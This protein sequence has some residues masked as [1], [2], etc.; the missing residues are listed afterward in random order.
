[1][2]PSNS[3]NPLNRVPPQPAELPPSYQQTQE[4]D[5]A[6]S[7]KSREILESIAGFT[8]ARKVQI[9]VLAAKT[10]NE[11]PGQGPHRIYFSATGAS[12][13]GVREVREAPHPRLNQWIKDKLSFLDKVQLGRLAFATGHW[14]EFKQS[15]D[16]NPNSVNN[17]ISKFFQ[18]YFAREGTDQ[19]TLKLWQILE[20]RLFYPGV[21]DKLETALT[22]LT[23]YPV[24]AIQPDGQSSCNHAF[25][26][27]VVT[28]I[29]I[30][31]LSTGD[32]GRLGHYLKITNETTTRIKD[33][34]RDSALG[35]YAA[36]DNFVES[37]GPEENLYQKLLLALDRRQRRDIRE[38][39]EAELKRLGIS[40]GGY[41][42]H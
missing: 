15:V 7:E 20:H 24:E 29:V 31:N 23:E 12:Q 4:D 28:R 39:L 22:S 3:S 35:L 42:S 30:D 5:I 13:V 32:L 8:P 37:S 36:F 9:M 10:L 1:M 19:G 34:F 6:L 33:E 11:Q 18:E 41:V 21:N 27:A 2:S 16:E 38:E 14:R 25:N 26:Y 17:Q 40:I